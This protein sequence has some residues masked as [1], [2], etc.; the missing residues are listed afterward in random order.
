MGFILNV[1][2][3]SF[4]INLGFKWSTAYDGFKGDVRKQTLV[5]QILNQIASCQC[6]PAL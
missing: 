6:S 1:I 2:F 3:Q 4:T 5:N